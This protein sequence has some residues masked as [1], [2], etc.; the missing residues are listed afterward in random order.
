MGMCTSIICMVH[1]LAI[2]VLLVLG[3]ESALWA[4]EQEWV[5]LTFIG[6]SLL[7]GLVSFLA[8]YKK[9]K[10]HFV[11]VLFL[12]GFLLLVNGEGLPDEVLSTALSVIGAIVIVYAHLQ[13]I[14]WRNHA[15][16]A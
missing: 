15:R 16:I 1:C 3:L 12:S 7:I 6:L 8:G 9:H 11:P 10:Q 2:P 13:N 14:K 4:I 5:E